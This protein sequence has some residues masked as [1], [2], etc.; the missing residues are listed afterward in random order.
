MEI[1][2]EKESE[3]TELARQYLQKLSSG[4]NE[5]AGQ[6]ATELLADLK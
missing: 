5:Q 1:M 4:S 3:A 6:A 2:K